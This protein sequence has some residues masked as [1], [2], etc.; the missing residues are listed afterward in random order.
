MSGPDGYDVLKD[1]ALFQDLV[2]NQ[3]LIKLMLFFYIMGDDILVTLNMTN[4]EKTNTKM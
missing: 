4:D 1:T 3:K 2:H